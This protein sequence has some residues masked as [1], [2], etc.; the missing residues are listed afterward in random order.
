MDTLNKE[1][2]NIKTFNCKGFKARNYSYVSKLFEDVSLLLIQEH[3]LYRFEF[4]NFSKV[5]NNAIFHAQSSMDENRL[6]RGR[7]YG[8]TAILYK[9]NINANITPIETSTPRL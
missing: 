8:G 7:P 1:D 4:D 5:L 9:S 3:W 2:L 6:R